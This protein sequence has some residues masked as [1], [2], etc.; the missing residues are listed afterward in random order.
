MCIRYRA[1]F[2][3]RSY[4]HSSPDGPSSSLKLSATLGDP[5]VDAANRPSLSDSRP[6]RLRSHSANSGVEAGC[7]ISL[8]AE[9]SRTAVSKTESHAAHYDGAVLATSA[10][11]NSRMINLHHKDM[12]SVKKKLFS[13]GSL[14]TA[15]GRDR[16]GCT[17]LSVL[18]ASASAVA[19]E[20]VSSQMQPKAGASA[21]EEKKITA[22]KHPPLTKEKLTGKSR[23]EGGFQVD[24]SVAEEFAPSI[25]GKAVI[26][27]VSRAATNL[28]RPVGPKEGT[29][30]AIIGD[31]VEAP[32][33]KAGNKLATLP[34]QQPLQSIVKPS[35]AAVLPS[36]LEL[37][38]DRPPKIESVS[39]PSLTSDTPPSQ[40]NALNR[41]VASIKHDGAD[42][43][44]SSRA[45]RGGIILESA[46][47]AVAAIEREQVQRAREITST[48]NDSNPFAQANDSILHHRILEAQAMNRKGDEQGATMHK[49]S[50]WNNVK[51]PPQLP[52][53]A[54]S[55]DTIDT[56]IAP[57]KKS[58]RLRG[59]RAVRAELEAIE[60]KEE[61]STASL[62]RETAQPTESTLPIET[63][64]DSAPTNS[65][66]SVE[67][68][69]S[70]VRRPSL[71][72]SG[73]LA[74]ALRNMVGSA[75]LPTEESVSLSP[76]DAEDFSY[77]NTRGS[78]DSLEE[79]SGLLSPFEEDGDLLSRATSLAESLH[80][81]A[82][83]SA[84]SER[85]DE[86]TTSDFEHDSKLDGE[87]TT[88]T[89]SS[90]TDSKNMSSST[91]GSA[92]AKNSEVKLINS[93]DILSEKQTN[94]EAT[95]V[96]TTQPALAANQPLSLSL[97]SIGESPSH[98]NN[99]ALVEKTGLTPS[100]AQDGTASGQLRRPEHG[101]Q[102]PWVKGETIGQ[103][104]FGRVYRGLNE[105][106]G[107]L[108]A[109]KQIYL[110]DGSEKEVESLR[111]EIRLMKSLSHKNIVRY[112]G[113]S[114]SDRYLFIIM[115]Y[116]PGGSISSMLGQFGAFS[117]PLVRYYRFHSA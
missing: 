29:H 106:T 15:A 59:A 85:D 84:S 20:S 31:V 98:E 113:T 6:S 40:S 65:G 83:Q 27:K 67:N 57:D 111:G 116:V 64:V 86:Y 48:I 62:S 5:R 1:T 58:G 75:K 16:D 87:V 11:L 37:T 115:E 52:D 42:K 25:T 53:P 49:F 12:N 73:G 90:Q 4:L 50:L 54:S 76:Y 72:G 44:F 96:L 81:H 108:L 94:L 99:F 36:R 55:E 95:M 10:S 32:S 78:L 19:L 38:S 77:L 66:T 46:I 91:G 22:V 74:S 70:F 51:K 107:E 82:M 47:A 117:E 14:D 105:S 79:G 92:L 2:P 43:T 21:K 109:V 60:A 8:A 9:R 26:P 39:S 35:D 69:P 3:D 41:N 17:N 18:T 110:V 61:Q 80:L 30:S 45:D 102:I 114:V 13:A 28:P 100:A 88:E 71:S 33:T 56:S 89:G 112:L 24:A 34:K 68:T 97:H 103:G 104:T 23:G 101:K 63:P 7:A 93:A